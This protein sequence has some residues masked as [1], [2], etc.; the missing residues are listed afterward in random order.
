M[1]L[2]DFFLSDDKKIA[3]HQRRLT[4]RDAQP[5]DR[6]ASARWLVDHGSPAALLALLTRFDI[7]LTHQMNDKAERDVVFGLAAEKGEAIL[8]PLR[9]WLKRG[10]QFAMP[11]RLYQ[12]LTSA[13]DALVAVFEVLAYEREKDD[14]KP[15]KKRDLLIWLA[16]HRDPRVID[17]ASPFLADFDESVRYGAAEAMIAQGS[18]AAR[19]PL[20][21]RMVH[22][23]EDSNR[24]RHR[25]AE[26]F[27]QRRWSVD[28]V[29]QAKLHVPESFAVRDGRIVAA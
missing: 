28:E 24:L 6:E 14:F 25:I 3:K 12:E 17:A 13:E 16:Q 7:S 23:D 15:E 5:E 2:L 11:L 29:D 22:A 27:A 10:R 21:A 1:G 4:N 19:G 9:Q 26:V 20:L 18:E 8:K